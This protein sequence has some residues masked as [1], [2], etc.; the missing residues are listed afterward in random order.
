[1]DLIKETFYNDK[2]NNKNENKTLRNKHKQ[3]KLLLWT[4][5]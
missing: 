5:I 3:R 4:F 1:M 2:N